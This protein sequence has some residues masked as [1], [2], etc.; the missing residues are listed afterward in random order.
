[1]RESSASPRTPGRP[2]ALGGP[3][4]AVALVVL[5]GSD[6]R[7]F[8]R[9]TVQG[10]PSTALFWRDREVGVH[11]VYDSSRDLRASVVHAAVARSVGTWNAAAETCSDFRLEDRGAPTDTAT[12]LLGG[13]HDGENRIV[14][15]YEDWPDDAAP[16]TLALTT[17]VYRRSTGEIL[18]AD[19]DLNGRDYAW[20]DAD[21]PALAD[22]DLENTLTHELGHLLGLAHVDDPEATMY[23][24]SESGELAKRD[25]AEDD[26]AGLCF[27]YPAGVASPG[28]P[29]L[30]GRPLS[31]GCHVARRAPRAS[32]HPLALALVLMV[33]ALR[34]TRRARR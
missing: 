7:A 2:W 3:A 28:A 9:S 19:I 8:E 24:R 4:A 21:D 17:T 13:P 22:T 18:D 6:A 29:Y 26:V 5:A 25:L 27:I 20:T 34:R 12:N 23:A 14:F 33:G 30:P 11:P 10:D 16:G 31:S 1:M 15:R 32:F